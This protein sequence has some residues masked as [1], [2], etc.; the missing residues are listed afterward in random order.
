MSVPLKQK[1]HALLVPGR[2]RVLFPLI[3]CLLN[4]LQNRVLDFFGSNSN[5]VMT[6]AKHR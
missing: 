1:L 2:E 5:R 4:G 3:P 6:V